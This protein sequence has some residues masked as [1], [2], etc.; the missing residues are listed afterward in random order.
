MV[1]LNYQQSEK[2]S[3]ATV[4]P[5][6]AKRFKNYKK[7]WKVN[8]LTLVDDVHPHPVLR[9]LS[10]KSQSG[11]FGPKAG[12]VSGLDALLAGLS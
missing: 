10:L 7:Q 12:V 4:Q 11:T 9:D 5:K 2:D 1:V 6:A 3:Y 8:L